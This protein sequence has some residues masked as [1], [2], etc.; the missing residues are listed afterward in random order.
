[1]SGGQPFL[2][3]EPALGGG[4]SDALERAVPIQAVNRGAELLERALG[5]PL[6]P[7]KCGPRAAL[8]SIGPHV[9]FC[10]SVSQCNSSPHFTCTAEQTTGARVPC[11]SKDGVARKVCRVALSTTIFCIPF[12]MQL[13]GGD[14]EFWAGRVYP[15]RAYGSL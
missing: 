3:V 4:V 11:W 14:A 12:I 7:L 6:F 10:F 5:R 15:G 9:P 2:Q 13:Q 1:M 8:W